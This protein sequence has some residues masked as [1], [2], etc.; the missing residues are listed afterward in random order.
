MWYIHTGCT[1][2]NI[3]LNHRYALV[4]HDNHVQQWII[5]ISYMYHC[6][7]LLRDEVTVSWWV[8]CITLVTLLSRR[9]SPVSVPWHTQVSTHEYGLL[10][11]FNESTMHIPNRLSL[12]TAIFKSKLSFT[13]HPLPCWMRWHS[14]YATVKL[15]KS[16]LL[17]DLWRCVLYLSHS[18]SC[19]KMLNLL[20]FNINNI[21]YTLD[22]LNAFH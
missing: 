5:N 16:P 6:W 21:F 9:A 3:C 20:R 10:K 4:H 19:H 14:R 18:I 17:T 7:N 12:S 1:S 15:Y 8:V 22:T 11:T 13:W 2:A